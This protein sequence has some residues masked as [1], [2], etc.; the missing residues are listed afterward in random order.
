MIYQDAN[1]RV[2]GWSPDSM[3]RPISLGLYQKQLAF[4]FLERST[5]V[6]FGFDECEHIDQ[7]PHGRDGHAPFLRDAKSNFKETLG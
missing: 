7:S 2:T 4:G 3:M 1:D 6:L 5:G